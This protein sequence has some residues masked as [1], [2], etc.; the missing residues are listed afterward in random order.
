MKKIVTTVT[1]LLNLFIYSQNVR[2]HFFTDML[3][4]AEIEFQEMEGFIPIN[5]EEDEPSYCYHPVLGC[6]Y[7]MHKSFNKEKDVY[8]V[9]EVIPEKI[10]GKL[11][12]KER[13]RSLPIDE[14]DVDVGYISYIDKN[15]LKDKYNATEGVSFY[16][17]M[18]KRLDDKYALCKKVYIEKEDVGS[19]R[20]LLLYNKE[21]EWYIKDLINHM[22]LSVRFKE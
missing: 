22:Y 2:E 17:K 11:I 7:I 6:F 5:V 18:R 20:I 15:I 9:Y 3:R 1:L 4:N 10:D 19:I 14:A 12:F 16:L 13:P 21:N 8:V